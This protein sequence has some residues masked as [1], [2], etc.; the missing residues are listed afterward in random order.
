VRL[1]HKVEACLADLTRD[2]VIYVPLPFCKIFHVKFDFPTMAVLLIRHGESCGQRSRAAPIDDSLS[3]TGLEQARVLARALQ[4]DGV[5]I[6]HVVASPLRRALQ[7]EMVS[8]FTT[9]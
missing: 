3:E 8:S 1:E 5:V 2:D 6:D 9:S 4:T 7:V